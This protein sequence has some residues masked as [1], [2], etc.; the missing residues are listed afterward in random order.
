[1]VAFTVDLE[2]WYHGLEI[3]I[4][5]WPKREERLRKGLDVLLSLLDK[6]D[7]KATFFILG[8]IAD[9]YPEVVREIDALGHEIGSH[10]Y[11]HR[12]VYD[13]SP[14]EFKEDILRTSGA[15]S[16]LTGKKVEGFRAPYFSITSASVWA[17]D[18][19]KECGYTY[20]CSISPVVTWRYGIPGARENLYYMPRHGLWEYSLSTFR[21]CGKKLGV[22][23]AY[24]RLFPYSMARHSLSALSSAGIPAMFYCHPWEYDPGHPRERSIS[25]KAQITHYTG[26]GRMAYRTAQLLADFKCDT[27]SAIIASQKNQ[28]PLAHQNG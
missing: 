5:D 24:M 15:L 14:G 10:S 23:G 9:R 22:G 17:L 6:A 18:I 1:M 12:K 7:T 13:L 27:V 3:E 25:L 19:L 11:W 20:D 8:W 2:D 4:S 26:L 21:F 28:R 16:Q